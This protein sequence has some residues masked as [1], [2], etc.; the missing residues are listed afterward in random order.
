LHEPQNKMMNKENKHC[1]SR[2]L[3]LWINRLTAKARLSCRVCHQP[4][5][6]CWFYR[7][8]TKP[9]PAFKLGF[10]WNKWKKAHPHSFK[11]ERQMHEPQNEMMIKEN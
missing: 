1:M 4:E 10:R 11:R 2:K 9:A 5:G 7:K 3:K 6:W 8:L